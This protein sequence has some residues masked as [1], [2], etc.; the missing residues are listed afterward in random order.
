[1]KIKSVLA[2]A[3]AMTAVVAVASPAAAVTVTSVQIKSTVEVLQVAEL[4]L[5]ANGV[6]VAQGKTATA[7]SVYVNGPA[8]P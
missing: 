6:N 1:M 3:A 8:V 5:F 2:A 4:Q 7:T